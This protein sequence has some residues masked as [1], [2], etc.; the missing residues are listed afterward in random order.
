[1]DAQHGHQRKEWPAGFVFWVV[2]GNESD[3]GSPWH[4]LLYLLQK[5]LPAGFLRFQVEVQGGLFHD[6]YSLNWGLHQ[7]LYWASYAEFLY[8][9]M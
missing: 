8:N 6:L 2:G 4:H 5:H 3:Q 9:L 1:M 7:A